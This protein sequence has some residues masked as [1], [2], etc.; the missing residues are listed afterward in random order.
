MSNIRFKALEMAM[1]RPRRQLPVYPDRISDYYGELAFN[2]SVM[3]EYMSREAFN[4]VVHA[5]EMGVKIDRLIADQV[6]SAM[7][8]WALS[9][10]ATHFTH[11]FHPLTGSTAEK[12][13]A[14]VFPTGDGHAIE[15]FNAN[16]LIQQE[17]DASSFPSGGIRNTFEARGYTA[18]DPTS[19]A[20]IM[21][22][23]LCIPTIFVSYTGEALDY[24]TPLLKASSSL[25]REAT[26]V[27]QYFDENVK[28]VF[29]TL[30]WEQE[31]FLVDTALYNARPDLSL[32]GRT[33]FGHSSAKDQQLSDHYFGIIPEKVIEFM[34]EFEYEAHRLGIPVRT[35]HNEV[36]PNQFECA[37]VYEEVN[38]AVDHNQL[39]MH[40]LEKVG[41][42]HG[43][44]VLLHEKPYAG[45]NG[46]GKHN[47][48]SMSTNTGENLLSPGKTPQANLQFLVFLSSI[49][50]ALDTHADLL[51]AYIAS[52]GNDLRLGGHEAPPAII[53]A[54]IG[55]QL[56]DTL[57]QIEK[58]DKASLKRKTSGK[59]MNINIP[60]IPEILLDNTDRNRTSPFAFTGNKFEFRAVGSTSSCAKPMIA[61]NLIVADQLRKFRQEA[62][63]LMAD[64]VE[65]EDAIFRVVK[66][67][68]A[69]SKR[70]RFEGNSYSEEW[71]KEAAKRGL[72]NIP[73]TPHALK[74]LLRKEAIR[75]FEE[76]QVLS[77]REVRAR[78]EIK[79]ENYT[80][81]VQ[82][83]SR[84]MGDLA[85][86]HIVPIAI[87]YQNQLIE[88]VKGLKE[89][90]DSKTYTA[91][92]KNQLDTIREISEH[93]AVI[94]TEVHKMTEARKIANAIDNVEKQALAYR[95]DVLSYFDIIRYHVDKLELLVDNELWPLPKYR[96]LLF[97]R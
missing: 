20:F 17:P 77:E 40:L 10:G 35:R 66:K 97:V 44:T 34:R 63:K 2:Q 60:K 61:L 69:E 30:G 82:I 64:G 68:V 74:S 71:V 41:K 42:R 19:P 7:K 24:K 54:F 6:A 13:D 53:S 84:V 58:L 18:W 56:S 65:K 16:E 22:R 72:S 75:L 27:C 87:R 59:G 70:I 25:D 45:V 39:I 48:W 91:L 11:W 55:S 32:S 78:Y 89:V 23:T 83:E 8:S 86:N 15:A 9:K 62:D 43:Y 92:S 29:A 73:D 76:H 96:E 49:L 1:A 33:L 88:N 93:I 31:Y 95:E 79:L 36:A 14:F 3:R 5:A 26:A 90:L 50:K 51:R 4:S 46:S 12:H 67:Y 52:A 85:I 81:K 57:D 28:R 38:V 21:D 80:R 94:R 47:N 37:P